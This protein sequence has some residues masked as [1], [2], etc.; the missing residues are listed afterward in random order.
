MSQRENCIFCKI[1]KG[2]VPAVK[3]CEDDL[4]I[5]FMD[6]MPANEGHTLIIARDHYESL[7]D[8]DETVLVAVARASRR[9]AR[10]LQ[11][12]LQPD[13]LRVSQFNGAAAGQTV[14]HYHVHLI[15][16]HAGERPGSHGRKRADPAELQRVAERIRA[17]LED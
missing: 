11:R 9:I 17:G 7:L 2:E 15:P 6:I 5:T 12:R 16:M 13:G 3:V 1:V 14:F 8:I 4:T 10:A